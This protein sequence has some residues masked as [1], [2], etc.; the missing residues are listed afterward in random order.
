MLKLKK[1]FEIDQRDNIIDLNWSVDWIMKNSQSYNKESGA[2]IAEQTLTGS[3]RRQ[4]MMKLQR[5]RA[6]PEA[7]ASNLLKIH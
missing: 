2:I 1:P 3:S 5:T 7:E 4:Q 6:I